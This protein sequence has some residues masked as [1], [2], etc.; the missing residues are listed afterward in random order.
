MSRVWAKV[1]RTRTLRVSLGSHLASVQRSTQSTLSRIST[2]NLLHPAW[3]HLMRCRMASKIWV[4][5][6]AHLFCALASLLAAVYNSN[7][8]WLRSHQWLQQRQP[9]GTYS[10][11]VAAMLRHVVWLDVRLYSCQSPRKTCPAPSKIAVR[12]VKNRMSESKMEQR[13]VTGAPF[14]HRLCADLKLTRP[15][16]KIHHSKTSTRKLTL[17]EPVFTSLSLKK[18]HLN[19][20]ICRVCLIKSTKS[21]KWLKTSLVKR[22]LSIHYHC[23][24][25][26]FWFWFLPSW[27][28]KWWSCGEL[29]S[30]TCFQTA[31]LKSFE[32]VGICLQHIAERADASSWAPIARTRVIHPRHQAQLG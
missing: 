4:W 19:A 13:M 28:V 22:K 15:R 3:W 16:F 25:L 30:W 6:K 12:S 17:W 2:S 18:S 20:S 8:A 11:R 9:L 32:K 27:T 23:Y 14:S 29:K 1:L 5:T 21:S 26:R 7:T 10:K 24:R 31:C